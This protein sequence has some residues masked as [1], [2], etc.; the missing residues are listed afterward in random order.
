MASWN[1]D[2]VIGRGFPLHEA[3]LL[4][5]LEELRVE[6]LISKDESP[7]DIPLFHIDFH[8]YVGW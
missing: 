7:I 1:T 2:D 5:D 6:V 8:L 3:L 4:I